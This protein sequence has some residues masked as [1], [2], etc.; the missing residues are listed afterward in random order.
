MFEYLSKHL[1][2]KAF[3]INEQWKDIHWK[4]LR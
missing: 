3:Q 4:K 2:H 1:E